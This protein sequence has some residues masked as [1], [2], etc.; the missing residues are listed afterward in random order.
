MWTTFRSSS[1]AVRRPQRLAETSRLTTAE[2][3]PSSANR[4]GTNNSVASLV[5]ELVSE[6]T[7][8]AIYCRP[9]HFR[10]SFRADSECHILQASSLSSCAPAGTSCTSTRSRTGT[11]A[12]PGSR[13]SSPSSQ[14][15]CASSP[16]ALVFRQHVPVHPIMHAQGPAPG[17]LSG[18]KRNRHSVS[19]AR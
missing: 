8:S 11:A 1:F 7:L 12:A 16:F 14:S 2:F 5:S 13:P 17:Q 3:G 19:A 4:V 6:L 15:S 9:L 18:G 10:A